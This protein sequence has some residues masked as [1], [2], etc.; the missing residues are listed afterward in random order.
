M[1]NFG[2]ESECEDKMKA[3]FFNIKEKIMDPKNRKKNVEN[4]VFFLISIVIIIIVSGYIFKEDETVQT[5]VENSSNF[6][7]S[8]TFEKKLAD[9]LSKI[10]GAGSVDVMVS[11]QAGVETVPLLDTK[12]RSTV[13]KENGS[14]TS[15]VTEQND[16]E[17]SIIFNQEKNGNK[18]PYISK[19]IMPKVEGVIVTCDGGGDVTVKADIISAVQAVTGVNANKIQVFPRG[20]KR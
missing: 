19:T 3:I 20:N 11:Y 15:R 4:L 18:N 6:F 10:E 17:T 14:D 2:G 12:D 13:T 5:K 8:E 16:V 9:I 1:R 7:D